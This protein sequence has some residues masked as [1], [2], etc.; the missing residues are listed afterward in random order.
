MFISA[1]IIPL[2]REPSFVFSPLKSQFSTIAFTEQM[3]CFCA[4]NV[5]RRIVAVVRDAAKRQTETFTKHS[6]HA[7]MCSASRAHSVESSWQKNMPT[8]MERYFLNA[9]FSFAHFKP[10]LP[11]TPFS[12]FARPSALLNIVDVFA[13]RVTSLALARSWKWTICSSTKRKSVSVA[14]RATLH[15]KTPSFTLWK[16][17]HIAKHAHWNFEWHSK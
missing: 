16:A 9:I 2:K 8:V 12:R 1:T 13:R 6:E 3:E 10:F 5:H 17:S 15:S 11:F 7:G 4:R 14:L